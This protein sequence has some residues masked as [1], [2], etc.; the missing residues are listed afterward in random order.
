MHGDSEGDDVKDGEGTGDDKMKDGDAVEV[1]QDSVMG[2][3]IQ[4]AVQSGG[5]EYDAIEMV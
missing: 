1:V 2:D 5:D 4:D 3:E